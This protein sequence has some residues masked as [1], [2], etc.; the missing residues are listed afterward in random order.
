MS[1]IIDI[2]I[3]H[4]SKSLALHKYFANITMK[5][6]CGCAISRKPYS[7][8]TLG[9]PIIFLLC[10][11]SASFVYFAY[12]RVASFLLTAEQIN[13]HSLNLFYPLPSATHFTSPYPHPP[14]HTR[15]IPDPNSTTTLKPLQP[16][17]PN[18]CQV[19]IYHHTKHHSY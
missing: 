8:L 6:A 17:I 16:P 13:L 9:T 7:Y 15:P 1:I 18:L 3:I 19:P 11:P 4:H 2:I 5:F 10:Q 14:H 12:L